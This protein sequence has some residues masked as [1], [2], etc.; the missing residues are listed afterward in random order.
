MK[1]NKNKL[2]SKIIYNFHPNPNTHLV[3][4]VTFM[5]LLCLK[6]LKKFVC[7]QIFHGK[8]APNNSRY[9][10]LRVPKFEAKVDTI[11]LERVLRKI[12]YF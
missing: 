8:G 7:L 9:Y 4:A 1:C 12:W 10:G 3:Y 11:Q 5:L 2:N 6:Q